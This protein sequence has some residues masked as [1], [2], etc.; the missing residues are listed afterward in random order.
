MTS[1]IRMGAT[2]AMSYIEAPFFIKQAKGNFHLFFRVRCLNYMGRQHC[3]KGTKF[4][5][6]ASHNVLKCYFSE[7]MKQKGD[8]AM[9]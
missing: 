5:L 6:L 3:K 7:C 4:L 9:L 2:V 1:Y 8:R